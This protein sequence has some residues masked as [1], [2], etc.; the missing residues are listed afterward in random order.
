MLLQVRKTIKMNLSFSDE[1][2]SGRIESLAIVDIR[3]GGWKSS[4]SDL[5][6]KTL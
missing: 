2:S 1:L 5:L 4:Y 3:E 6:K